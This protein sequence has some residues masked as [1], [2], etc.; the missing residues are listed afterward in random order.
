MRKAGPFDAQVSGH[1]L[2]FETKESLMRLGMQ[3][4][5]NDQCGNQKTFHA[6]DHGPAPFAKS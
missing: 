5:G 6:E 2:T 3:R 4:A 1:D